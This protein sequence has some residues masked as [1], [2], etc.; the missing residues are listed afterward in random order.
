MTYDG[1]TWAAPLTIASSNTVSVSCASADLCVAVDTGGDALL[2][3]G[4]SWADNPEIDPER[5]AA[6]VL[7][8]E[9]RI[10]RCH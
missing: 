6:G 1:T 9:Y 5:A 7:R 10:L 3:N 8:T 2:Y 4:S